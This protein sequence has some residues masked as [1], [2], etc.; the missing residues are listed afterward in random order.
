M[1][2]LLAALVS[3]GMSVAAQFTLKRGVSAAASSGAGDGLATSGAQGLLGML[4]NPF[5]LLGLAL[6]AASAVVWLSV[7]SRWDVSKAYPLV[8]LGFAMTAAVGWMLGENV[9]LSRIIG[10]IAICGGVMVVARS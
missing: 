8:G 6:Y 9:T 4:T 1:N 7:L 5:V 10:V 2:P 3:I